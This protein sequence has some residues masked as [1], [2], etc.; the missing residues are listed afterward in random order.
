MGPSINDIT[1]FWDFWSLPPPCH[2]FYYVP[3]W[4][5]VIF[6]QIPPPPSGWCHLWMAPIGMYVIC[7]CK[8]ERSFINIHIVSELHNIHFFWFYWRSWG[9]MRW[10]ALCP[11]FSFF[12]LLNW[13]RFQ[14]V[15]YLILYNGH[16]I[17]WLAKK[18][19]V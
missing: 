13:R 3:L 15:L 14:D 9:A 5:N 2:P 7:I 16:V 10:D 1:H 11:P 12:F 8:K 6:L 17:I 19:V 4:S 18:I